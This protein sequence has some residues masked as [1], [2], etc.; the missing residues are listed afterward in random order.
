MSSE[1]ED[2][3]R[4]VYSVLRS[5]FDPV[6]SRSERS[7][8]V[9]LEVWSGKERSRPV[10]VE[11]DH[12]DRVN[13]WVRTSGD[14]PALPPSIERTDKEPKGRG[15]TDANGKGANSNLS[16]YDEFRTRRITR[17]GVS[18]EAD[19]RIVLEHLVR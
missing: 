12:A 11:F 19:A 16:S 4:F 1:I 9:H 2:L 17:L 13:F 5:R 6:P 18:A 10:G 15:W 3:K 8:R 7:G 14:V